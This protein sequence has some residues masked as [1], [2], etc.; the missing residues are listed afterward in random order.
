MKRQSLAASPHLCWVFLAGLVLCST[1]FARTGTI[2]R[3]E[4]EVLRANCELRPED[5]QAAFRRWTHPEAPVRASEGRTLQWGAARRRG[6]H[7]A[8]SNAGEAQPLSGAAA[9]ANGGR[10]RARDV[11]G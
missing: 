2:W 7:G 4:P 3:N 6:D 5:M 8:D 11:A 10:E 1:G 9:A